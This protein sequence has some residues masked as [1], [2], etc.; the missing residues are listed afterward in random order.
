MFKPNSLLI[1]LHSFTL[2]S[3]CFMLFPHIITSSHHLHICAFR[4]VFSFIFRH[5]SFITA[6]NRIGDRMLPCLTPP[7][8]SN[9]PVLPVYVLT[10]F[11]VISYV[12]FI[13]FTISGDIFSLVK[14]VQILLL[15]IL[16][17]ALS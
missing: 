1:L 13:R 9:N 17:N 14:H 8:V 5:I 4:S 7:F 15:S 10:Q 12:C 6:L 2:S 16:S 11:V 3:K